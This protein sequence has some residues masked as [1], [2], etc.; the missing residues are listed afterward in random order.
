MGGRGR[1]PARGQERQGPEC[2]SRR[3]DSGQRGPRKQQELGVAAP[4]PCSVHTGGWGRPHG[5]IGSIQNGGRWGPGNSGGRRLWVELLP[6][7]F[8]SSWPA[9]SSPVGCL[10]PACERLGRSAPSHFPFLTHSSRKG[11][12]CP[13]GATVAGGGVRSGY[14][15][16]CSHRQRGSRG[17]DGHRGAP[18]LSLGQGLEDGVH[19]LRDSCQGKFKLVLGKAVGGGSWGGLASAPAPGGLLEGEAGEVAWER[20]ESSWG[21]Y[22]DRWESWAAA[23]FPGEGWQLGSGQG[24]TVTLERTRPGRWSRTCSRVA[25]M[26]ISFTPGGAGG[27]GLL[28]SVQRRTGPR[29]PGASWGGRLGGPGKP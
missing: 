7:T 26:S 10:A 21:R 11:W 2:G 5:H 6:V 20:R 25:A 4:P 27:T 16:R 28:R 24:G 14:T 19:L 18:G 29:K 17:W 9:A 8:L 13:R 22:R 3:Q 1:R 23:G 15:D 12:T